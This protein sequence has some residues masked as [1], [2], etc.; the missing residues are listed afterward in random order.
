MTFFA[1]LQNLESFEITFVF[2][3]HRIIVPFYYKFNVIRRDSDPSYHKK[4]MHFSKSK[5]LIEEMFLIKLFK[6]I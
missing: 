3:Q 1:F 4:C 6:D 5:N 2:V